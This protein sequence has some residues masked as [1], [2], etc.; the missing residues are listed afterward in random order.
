MGILLRAKELKEKYKVKK[1]KLSLGVG[2]PWL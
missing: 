1:N 2:A